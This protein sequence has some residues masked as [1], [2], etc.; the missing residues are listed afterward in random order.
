MDDQLKQ[1]LFTQFDALAGKTTPT[2]L[3]SSG[4]VSAYNQSRADEIRE[5]GRTA[6]ANAPVR[7]TLGADTAKETLAGAQKVGESVERG[8]QKLNAIPDLEAGSHTP[9]LNAIGTEAKKTGALLETGLGAAAGAAQTAFAPIT[10]TLSKVF[11]NAGASP[12]PTA[13]VTEQPSPIAAKVSGSVNE[14]AT[15]H[16][17]AARNLMDALTVAGAATADI[18]GKT[19]PLNTDLGEAG[20]GVVSAVKEAPGQAM[21][22]YRDLQTISPEKA[23]DKS[24]EISRQRITPKLEQ[25]AFNEGRVGKQGLFKGAPITPSTQETRVAEAIQPYVESGSL[26]PR[27]EPSQ[28][29]DTINQEVSKINQGVKELVRNPRYNQPFTEREFDNAMAET[30]S[31]NRLI[32]AGDETAQKAYD[33]VVDEF[34]TFVD[35]KNVEGLL[36]ARQSFDAYIKQN[37]PK[38]FKDFELT[39]EINPRVQALRDV[40]TTANEFAADLLDKSQLSHVK[41]ITEPSMARDLIA[42]AR[43]FKDPEDFVRYVNENSSDY[44]GADLASQTARKTQ[45]TMNTI[46]QYPTTKSDDLR[47]IWNIAHSQKVS[48]AGDTFTSALRRESHMLQASENISTKVRGITQI[49]KIAQWL[50]NNPKKTLAALIAAGVLLEP[51]GVA[52]AKS[53]FGE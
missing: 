3:S 10:A 51:K 14:W 35:K 26:S 4:T 52:F 34:K 30:A 20:K 23:F 9:V 53:V 11:G 2:P 31:K 33:A 15:K 36:N 46:N 17:D 24:I 21:Q 22:T 18:G 12:S 7:N 50:K 25:E 19:N 48:T 37:F 45:G 13:S 47:D 28:L 38:A 41:S 39:G 49:G 27:M 44:A 32:F 6:R 5:I 1:R 40:R 43:N 42:K 8:A 29:R 16:P